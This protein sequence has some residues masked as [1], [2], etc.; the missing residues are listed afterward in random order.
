MWHVARS[1][2]LSTLRVFEAGDTPPFALEFELFESV[3]RDAQTAGPKRFPADHWAHY[4]LA[5][6]PWL[7]PGV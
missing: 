1:S 6:I 4:S 3:H 5:R 7:V 2:L